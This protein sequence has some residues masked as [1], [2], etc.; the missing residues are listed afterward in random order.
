MRKVRQGR[1][2]H[3]KIFQHAVIYQSNA[4]RGHALVVK[5]IKA[6]QFL[7]AKTLLSGVVYD[8]EKARQNL[9]ANLIREGLAFGYIFLAVSLVTVAEH[10][11]E[12]NRGGPSRKQCRSDGGVAD[13]R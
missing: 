3:F 4:L 5:L 8:A 9:F 13:W 1:A 10:F 11:M 7:G 2:R 6:Q 12:E